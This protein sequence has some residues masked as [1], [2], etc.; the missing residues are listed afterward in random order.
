MGPLLPFDLP[1]VDPGLALAAS[2]R[3]RAWCRWHVSPVIAE[4]LVLDGSGTDVLMLPSRLVLDVT[5]VLVN[6]QPVAGFD[7]SRSGWIEAH[8]GTFPDRLRS[9]SVTLT[10]GHDQLPE[11]IL[12]VVRGMAQRAAD[13]A[14]NGM[15]VA[16]GTDS[17]NVSY[18]RSAWGGAADLELLPT[19]RALLAPYRVPV[20]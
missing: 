18:G 5:E 9:V 11:E 16:Q 12:Q 17:F 15:V 4:T 1:G 6:G 8:Y 10:H 3:I 20:V 14:E 7:W 19:D 2:S 13:V